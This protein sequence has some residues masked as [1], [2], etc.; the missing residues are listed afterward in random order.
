MSHSPGFLLTSGW[1]GA[2]DVSKRSSSYWNN[3]WIQINICN[4]SLWHGSEVW[5]G[6][7]GTVTQNKNTSTLQQQ[8]T[9]EQRAMVAIASATVVGVLTESL[10]ADK[11]KSVIF[12]ASYLFWPIMS[13]EGGIWKR[14]PQREHRLCRCSWTFSRLEDKL[15]HPVR[16]PTLFEEMS[17]KVSNWLCRN[18][19]K[20]SLH[21]HQGVYLQ[22]KISIA[23]QKDT[24]WPCSVAVSPPR[25]LGLLPSG[26]PHAVP[27][28]TSPLPLLQQLVSGLET[29]DCIP[30]ITPCPPT[31][32][33]RVKVSCERWPCSSP[34]L[35][36][37]ESVDPC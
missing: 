8:P 36:L 11:I 2:A 27:T 1:Q 20:S 5:A 33:M 30:T 3:V 16:T 22:W 7:I 18:T 10:I 15:K 26:I 35:W 24:F 13:L 12:S 29:I 21:M 34:M 28:W 31:P 23:K 25:R 9:E 32:R 37:S 6:W 19:K 14:C 4:S 17:V